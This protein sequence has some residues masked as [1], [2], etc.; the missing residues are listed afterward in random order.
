MQGYQQGTQLQ[1]PQLAGVAFWRLIV[2]QAGL[3]GA[4]VDNRAVRFFLII[5]RQQACQAGQRG[6]GAKQQRAFTF[7]QM[8]GIAQGQDQC[9]LVQAAQ[10]AGRCGQECRRNVLV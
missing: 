4:E 1:A 8:E 5:P 2:G 7:G 9:L 6:E 3:G 10:G